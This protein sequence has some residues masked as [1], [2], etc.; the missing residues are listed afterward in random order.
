MNTTP[1]QTPNTSARTHLVLQLHL[2]G[3]SQPKK[4]SFR[5]SCRRLGL[6]WGINH[7]FN[8]RLDGDEQC[9]VRWIQWARA[10]G[11]VVLLCV[12]WLCVCVWLVALVRGWASCSRIGGGVRGGEGVG[13]VWGGGEGVGGVWG[14]GW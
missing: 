5:V 4:E 11:D 6:C 14:G 1:L 10:G 3:A 7:P 2:G 8:S 13:G 9:L 12:L